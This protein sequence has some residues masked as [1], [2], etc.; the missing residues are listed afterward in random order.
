MYNEINLKKNDYYIFSSLIFFLFI[1]F[2]LGEAIVNIILA[3]NSIF[4]FILFF[5]NRLSL[6][7]NFLS[8]FTLLI[9][10]LYILGI[11]IF[12]IENDFFKNFGL[13]RFILLSISIMIFVDSDNN[14]KFIYYLFLIL[15]FSISCDAL[16]QLFFG[17]SL[18]GI[19]KF[20]NTR[21][22][23]IFLDEEVLGS[24]LSKTFILLTILF[25]G[26]KKKTI[27]SLI[28]YFISSIILVTTYVSAERIAIFTITIFLIILVMTELKNKIH[29]FYF[30]IIS[31]LILTIS[32][33]FSEHL[34]VNVI[35]KTLAQLGANTI[36]NSLVKDTKIFKDW[37]NN[38]DIYSSDLKITP[39]NFIDDTFGVGKTNRNIYS[40]HFITAKNI[41]IDNLWFGAGIKSYSKNCSKNKY[42]LK[43]HPY[44][45]RRCSTHPHN[46]YLQ[47]LSEI[48][49]LGFIFFICIFLLL[50][51]LNLEDIF[52]NKKNTLS[53][54]GLVI[55]FL[56]L[57]SGNFFGTWYGSFI[58]I[59]LGLNFK[60]FLLKKSQTYKKNSWE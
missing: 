56:P 32:I 30:I 54:L 15:L 44:S 22:T 50:F 59:F 36:A 26:L 27:E 10:Y 35:S 51:Y 46:I 20:E 39:E 48:G 3:L 29:K 13:I 57:P 24:F 45:D 42:N 53:M 21:V 14:K 4:I 7:I 11:G 33:N 49:L 38:V 47:I 28:F 19:E 41:W 31:F 8:F 34:K 16:I 23:G 60:N 52:K 2:I 6:N 55:I 43:G 12:R 25:V 17:K 1:G 9:F 5:K 40:A 58:W 18:I 37:S